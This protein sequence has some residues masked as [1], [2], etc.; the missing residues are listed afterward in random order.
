MEEDKIVSGK[1]SSG[2]EFK[3]DKRIMDDARFLY[4]LAK[5]QD[6]NAGADVKSKAIVGLLGLVFGQDEGVLNFMNAVA[7]VNDGVCSVDKMI[8]E[9]MEIFQ[10]LE[11]KN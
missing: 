3:I 1:T 2:I 10:S 9:L 4:Y 8:A 5:A 6:D 7:A 11:A